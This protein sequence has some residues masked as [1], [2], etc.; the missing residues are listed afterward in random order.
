MPVARRMIFEGRTMRAVRICGFWVIVGVLCL[1]FDRPLARWMLDGG[2]P[3]DVRAL[4]HRVEA[5]GHTYGLICIAI[6]VYLLDVGR[7]N[8]VAGMVGAFAAAGIAADLVKICVWRV[9]PCRMEDVMAST[10]SYYGNLIT[11]ETDRLTIALDSTYHSFPSAHTACAVALAFALGKM[12]P[13]ARTWFYFL[14]AMCALNRIDGGA[15]FA[16]DVCWGAALGYGTAATMALVNWE[17]VALRLSW[18]S[19]QNRIR[20]PVFLDGKLG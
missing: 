8:R 18:H 12:Y 13:Q 17:P 7:R 1:A 16:S 19:N 3:G 6:T 9:R 11:A 14:A 20:G 10:S 5:F 15:H 2:L 4:F